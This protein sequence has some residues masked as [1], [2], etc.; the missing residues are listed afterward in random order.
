MLLEGE[1]LKERK[2]L[3]TQ[4]S[5]QRVVAKTQVDSHVDQRQQKLLHHR[6]L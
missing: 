3:D 5:M 4:Q 1:V 2:E 6:K